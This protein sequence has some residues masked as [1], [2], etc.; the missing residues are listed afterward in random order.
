MRRLRT[1]RRHRAA[2]PTADSRL[3]RRIPA[4]P[5][6][7]HGH[8]E[9]PPETPGASERTARVPPLPLRDQETTWKH[10]GEVFRLDPGARRRAPRTELRCDAF[11]R[12][13]T[14]RCTT[15]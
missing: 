11:L 9:T 14:I 12:R 8:R 1:F 3:P 13:E 2:C 15:S 6:A 4:V 10:V 5:T 7:F